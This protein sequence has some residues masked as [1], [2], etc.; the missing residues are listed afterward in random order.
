[1][2]NIIISCATVIPLLLKNYPHA[3]FCFAAARSVDKKNKTIEDYRLTQRYKLY[4]YFMPL[5]FGDVTFQHKK[6]DTISSYMLFNKSS[7]FPLED[8]ELILR[9]TYPGLLNI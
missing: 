1:M 8:V 6:Y 4:C 9:N 5:K 2:P 3:S 7:R